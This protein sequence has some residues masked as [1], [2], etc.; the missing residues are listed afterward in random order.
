MVSPSGM[1]EW[2]IANSSQRDNRRDLRAQPRLRRNRQLPMNEPDAFPDANQP[3]TPFGR[4]VIGRESRA[5]VPHRQMDEPGVCGEL[6]AN[7]SGP[8]MSYRV[9][10]ILLRYPIE[11]GSHGCVHLRVFD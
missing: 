10:K 1:R 7:L 2:L 9:P 6:D 4:G 3:Q 8:S 11:A 5:V